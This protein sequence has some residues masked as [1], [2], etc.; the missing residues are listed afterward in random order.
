MQPGTRAG[1]FALKGT[2]GS[3]STTGVQPITPSM[4]SIGGMAKSAEDLANLMGVLQGKAY[5]ASLTKS[6]KGLRLGFVDPSRWQ[7]A[8]FI[9]EP[10]KDF[11]EQFVGYLPMI[12]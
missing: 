6:W 5:R 12:K 2:L 11:R 10:R 8:D 1:L 7:P 3:I 9:A 4:D